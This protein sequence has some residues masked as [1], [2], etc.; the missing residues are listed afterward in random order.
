MG[1]FWKIVAMGA[2][3]AAA[4][5]VAKEII[6]RTERGESC[7]PAAVVK[8]VAAK[9]SNLCKSCFAAA[10][11]DPYDFDDFDD[12]DDFEAES[13]AADEG[14][15]FD[16]SDMESDKLTEDGYIM[17]F[18]ADDEPKSEADDTQDASAAQEDESAPSADENGETES[19]DK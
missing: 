2:T 10:E 7:S 6:E 11:D 13:D 5:V 4:V 15:D 1:S 9:V 8:G 14:V 3:A 19:E 17:E 16:T 18:D 12:F